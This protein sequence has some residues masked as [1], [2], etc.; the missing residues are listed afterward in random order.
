ME[1]KKSGS[2]GRPDSGGEFTD[3]ESRIHQAGFK[4]IFDGLQ[5]GLSFDGA[6]SGLQVVDPVMRSVIMDDYLKVTIA[7]R[8]FQEEKPLEEVAAE[9]KLP[10]ERVAEKK[11]EMLSEVQKAAVERFHQEAGTAVFDADGENGDPPKK[12]H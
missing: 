2:E 3:E 4:I 1:K 8:H 10:V 5:K 12:G 6:C 7:E 11:Q 9:L